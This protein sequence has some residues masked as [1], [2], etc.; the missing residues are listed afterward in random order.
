MGVPLGAAGA[1]R[2]AEL[3]SGQVAGDPRKVLVSEREVGLT[4][5]VADDQPQGAGVPH[6]TGLARLVGDEHDLEPA[7][8][9]RRGDVPEAP[10]LLGVADQRDHPVGLVEEHADRVG[11]ELAL[12]QHSVV[13]AC[14]LV[15]RGER[16]GQRQRAV[17]H[18]HGPG[19]G[20]AGGG[21]EAARDPLERGA[22]DHPDLLAAGGARAD[23]GAEQR[24]AARARPEQAL[25]LGLDDVDQDPR[26][27]PGELE[28]VGR[29]EL[30]RL[31]DRARRHGRGSLGSG[32]RVLGADHV[33]LAHPQLDLATAGG[34]AR[35]PDDQPTGD[36]PDAV[37][38]VA[39]GA[40][41]LAG[42]ELARP[43]ARRD[44]VELLV[45][46]PLEQATAAERSISG[47]L[48]SS[49]RKSFPAGA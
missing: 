26:K 25:A 3:G 34:G 1:E 10:R 17:E 13:R 19:A 28:Q 23:A 2:H 29:V 6:L 21:D 43:H 45:A 20:G 12:N 9:G 33:T 47:H 31:G 5:A 22:G 42:G 8:L 16:A 46:E 39:G 27:A 48:A 32:D 44:D 18:G 24:G 11:V 41:L 30:E 14:G 40:Q 35:G 36:Q 37:A 49:P 4:R 38:R 7:A 15:R